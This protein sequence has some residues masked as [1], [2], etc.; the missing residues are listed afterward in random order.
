MAITF[1]YGL[2]EKCVILVLKIPKGNMKAR[3]F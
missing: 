1:A 2:E 3:R